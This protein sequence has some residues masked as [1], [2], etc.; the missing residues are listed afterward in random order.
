MQ[1]TVKLLVTYSAKIDARNADQ[2][3]PLHKACAYNHWQVA[4]FLLD[5]G[6]SLEATDSDGFTPLLIT[7]R[8]GHAVRHFEFFLAVTAIEMI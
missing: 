7:A 1:E 5:N 2:Q 4:E 8:E 3:T 6:A